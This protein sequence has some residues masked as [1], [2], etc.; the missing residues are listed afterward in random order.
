MSKTVWKSWGADIH[1]TDPEPMIQELQACKCFSA[2]LK[3]PS[4]PS[5]H[6]ELQVNPRSKESIA[7]S[8][9]DCHDPILVQR[10][11]LQNLCSRIPCPRQACRNVHIAQFAGPVGWLKLYVMLGCIVPLPDENL[12]LY[13]CCACS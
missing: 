9:P 6:L 2:N 11:H 13:H 12:V 8:C 5:A 10:T 3:R 1:R 4:A 7:G